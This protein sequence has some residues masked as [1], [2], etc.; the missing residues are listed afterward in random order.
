MTEAP[1]T[2]KHG[3][4]AF[5]FVIVCVAMDMIGFGII[6]PVMPSLLS[7]LTGQPAAETVVIGGYLMATYGIL[8]FVAMPTSAVIHIQNSA[9]GPPSAM[10]VAT[11]AMLPVPTVAASAVIIA[12]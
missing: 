12:A 7:E 6:I 2:R 3:K 9:P 8:N 11:P 10:A 1:A 5:L 4:N